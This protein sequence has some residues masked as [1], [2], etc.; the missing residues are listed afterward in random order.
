LEA[1]AEALL[2]MFSRM[3]LLSSSIGDPIWLSIQEI[4]ERRTRLITILG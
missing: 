1:Q 2:L 3:N 4:N